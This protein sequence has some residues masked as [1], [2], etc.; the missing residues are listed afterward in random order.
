MAAPFQDCIV[1]FGDSLT[2][3]QEVPGSLQALFNANYRRTLDVLNR[4]YGGYTTEWLRPVFERTFARKEDAAAVPAVRLVTIWLGANDAVVPGASTN[5]HVPLP[6]Y[7]AHLRHFL[8]QLT[9]ASSPLA[10]AHT[11]GLNIVLAT[12][13]PVYR[14][15]MGG[16]EFAAQREPEVTAAYAQA[17]RELVDEFKA[18]QGESEQVKQGESEQAKQ[19]KQGEEDDGA[20]GDWRIGLVDMW[21]GIYE[22]AGL[23]SGT[24]GP[25]LEPFF[26]DGLHLTTAGYAVFWAQY[27]R[28]LETDFRGRG[29]NYADLADLPMRVP[30]V[31]EV[32][33]AQSVIDKLRL[34]AIR[35]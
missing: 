3:R 12:P 16:G 34:P 15:M 20:Q 28:L 10:A 31:S 1:L 19:A 27:T 30:D 8:E 26:N 29:L 17:V 25:D 35:Q 33:D 32:T 4:G 7:V 23:R 13:P 2:S 9:S 24:E 21:N 5:Q 14:G 22:A 11:A 6:T 18:K